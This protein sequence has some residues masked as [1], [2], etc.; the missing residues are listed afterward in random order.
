MTKTYLFYD[1]ETTGLNK[2]FD[3]ILQFAA[4]RTDLEL[5][6]LE[7]CNILLKLNP[8]VIP[9]PQ[10]ILT[11]NISVEQTQKGFC[12]YEAIKKIYQMLNQPETI[13]LG[14][15]N[16]SFDDEFL[17]FSFYRNLFKPYTHQ[18][19]NGCGRMDIYPIT[20]MYYLYKREAL[21]W[22][23]LNGKTSL[24]LEQINIVNNLVLGDAHD[25]LIDV[26]ITLELARHFIMY[27]EMWNYLSS[28]FVKQTDL[29]RIEKLSLALIVDGIFG[30]EKNYQSIVMFLGWHNH[31]KNQTLWLQLDSSQLTT[32]TLDSVAQTPYIFHKKAGENGL[33]LPYNTKFSQYLSPERLALAT[34]NQKWLEKNPKILAAITDY[35]KEYKYPIIPSLDI[36][37]ALYQN[38]FSSDYEQK[39]CEKFHSLSLKD[40]SNFISNFS[41]SKLQMQTIRVLGRNYP[42][43]LPEK[44]TNNF[45]TYLKNIMDGSSAPIDYKN[46]K[47]FTPKE[48]VTE[49]NE[50]KQRGNLTTKQI[51][52]LNEWCEYI[53]SLYSL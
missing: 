30:A 39:L 40:K 34:E 33:L 49:I 35:H 51:S 41:N 19:A 4:I 31:Y 29:Q 23:E 10:A 16:L 14:Y 42:E 2:C 26:E 32:T 5:N 36:D 15:N 25:A 8:D 3:Q 12:E 46:Q 28:Y 18:Y 47:H 11:H 53:Y 38:G 50:L 9:S 43:Y 1:I 17:R 13:S 27:R 44:Y 24:Q 6:E 48:M 21:K 22:P 37:A 52:L 7:R 20:I 45:K